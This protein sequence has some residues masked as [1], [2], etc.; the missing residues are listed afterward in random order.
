MSI[1]YIH[2]YRVVMDPDTSTDLS[3][4]SG[5]GDCGKIIIGA[6]LGDATPLKVYGLSFLCPQPIYNCSGFIG[7]DNSY[8]ASDNVITVTMA[9]SGM[10][11]CMRACVCV[12]IYGP[13]FLC[14]QPIYNCSG[15]IGHDN[16]YPASDNVI[17]VT[18][19]TSGI[20]VYVYM[21]LCV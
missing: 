10:C 4:P 20:Y 14:P 19:A 21:Y 18:M 6:A 7:H 13:S 12:C 15:F 1:S 2:T 3:V 16:S 5:T 11:V 9:T 8:P 17:T